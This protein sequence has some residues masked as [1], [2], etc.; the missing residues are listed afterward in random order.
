MHY[1]IACLHCIQAIRCI[2]VWLHAL[3]AS[4][5]M[6]YSTTCMVLHASYPMHYGAAACHCMQSIQCTL[7]WLHVITRKHSDT[8]I[9]YRLSDALWYS[10]YVNMQAIQCIMMQLHVIACKPPNAHWCGCMSF[11]GINPMHSGAAACP[12]MQATTTSSWVM[13][14]WAYI[15]VYTYNCSQHIPLG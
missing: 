14:N 2:I 7:V 1:G 15:S 12:C 4:Y 11:P 10:L 8:C 3:Y 13:S 6:Q 5:S 9:A